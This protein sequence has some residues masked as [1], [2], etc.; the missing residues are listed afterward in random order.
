MAKIWRDQCGSFLKTIIGWHL[1]D[2]I[3]SVINQHETVGMHCD[4]SE[5]KL[6][7]DLSEQGWAVSDTVFPK[8]LA[9]SLQSYANTCWINGGF[10]PAAIG[11]AHQ[12]QHKTALRGDTI[13]WIN[14]DISVPALA[15]LQA[16]LDRFQQ[17]LNHQF[18][19]GLKRRE[20]HFARYE[21]GSRYVRHIDQH[22]NSGHRKI[23]LVVYLNA[24]WDVQDGGELC[25]YHPEDR[26]LEM[27]RVLPLLARIVVFRSDTIEHEVH[28]GRQTR[29]SLTGW[30]RSDDPIA[31]IA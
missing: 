26:T 14:E 27:A 23:S 13:A 7:T 31:M 19:L 18:F 6:L 22:R 16:W 17:Q 3:N 21:P 9:L 11:R 20:M 2:V 1:G 30:F 8:E 28:L 12:Q 24:D 4:V 10:H 5:E 29:W 25:I 15:A